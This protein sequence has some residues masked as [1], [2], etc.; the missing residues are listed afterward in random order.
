MKESSIYIKSDVL[1][2]EDAI[3]TL[4]SPCSN[5]D[6]QKAIDELIGF[7]KRIKIFLAL[8]DEA[9]EQLIKRE[10]EDGVVGSKTDS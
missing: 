8:F 5:E 2:A 4:Q 3:T 10:E 6:A 1:A 9:E 7:V